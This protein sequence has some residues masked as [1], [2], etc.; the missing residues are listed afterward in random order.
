MDT[1]IDD[2]GRYTVKASDIEDALE[3][4]EAIAYIDSDDIELAG[5]NPA[6]SGLYY[7]TFRDIGQIEVV[8]SPV[9]NYCI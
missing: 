6:G 3:E 7:F 5:I 4:L 2:R 1:V 8:K 9:T